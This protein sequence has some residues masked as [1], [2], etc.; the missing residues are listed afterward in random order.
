MHQALTL[1]QQYNGLGFMD[2]IRSLGWKIVLGASSD[3]R[4]H[5]CTTVK[6]SL[7]RCGNVPYAPL[8]DLLNMLSTRLV[9]ESLNQ[10][11]GH[12]RQGTQVKLKLWDTY[13]W[14]GV[15]QPSIATGV[16]AKAWHLASTHFGQPGHLRTIM[17]G[18]RLN[19]D[20]SFGQYLPQDSTPAEPLKIH[21][22]LEIHGGGSKA[23]AALKAKEDFIKKALQTGFDPIEVRR[24]A[25]QLYQEAGAARV[26]SLVS[27]RRM[28]LSS[29]SLSRSQA[30]PPAGPADPRS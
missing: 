14:S 9:I 25:A 20:W 24:F 5:K 16:F 27:P 3:D 6:V 15:V 19:P 7:V 4:T 11:L 30:N 8:Q 13:V 29:K 22:V 10:K 21:M 1:V 23:E 2:L 28:P 26:R 12:V 18:Q 17:K